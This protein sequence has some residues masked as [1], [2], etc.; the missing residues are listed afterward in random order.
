MF[1]KWLTAF[2]E[3]VNPIPPAKV[4]QTEEEDGVTVYLSRD[5]IFDAVAAAGY[6]RLNVAEQ[7]TLDD[8][9]ATF[10]V[11]RGRISH[12]VIRYSKKGGI[13]APKVK[14]LPDHLRIIK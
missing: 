5:D 13:R 7:N 14:K 11:E 10:T 3:W 9:L 2:R 1:R 4:P 12:A 6:T 8:W